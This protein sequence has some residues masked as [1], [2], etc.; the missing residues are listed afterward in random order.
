MFC[1]DTPSYG[2]VGCWLSGCVGQWVGSGQI[3]NYQINLDLIRIIQFC[4]KI[5]VL[6]RYPQLWVGV[7]VVGWIGVYMHGLCEIT[8]NLINLD[9]IEIIQFWLMVGSFF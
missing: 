5:Y 2:W 8:K 1:G 4:L 3:T 7:L 9:L 6:W